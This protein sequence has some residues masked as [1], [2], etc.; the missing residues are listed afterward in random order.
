MGRRMPS[1]YSRRAAVGHL[2]EVHLSKGHLSEVHLR[3]GHPHLS[4]GHPHLTRRMT[5]S[6]DYVYPSHD[7]AACISEK[8]RKSGSLAFAG[9]GRSTQW[10]RPHQQYLPP[11]H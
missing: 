2:S 10:R 9:G 5:S 1:R 11:L 4:E 6:Y 7:N 8:I 3:E